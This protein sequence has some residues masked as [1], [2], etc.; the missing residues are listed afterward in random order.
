MHKSSSGLDLPMKILDMFGSGLPVIAL[1]YPV[2]DELVQHDV[3]GLKFI[4]RRELHE[5]LIFAVK[6]AEVYKVLK[7]GA[8]SESENR[9]EQSWEKALQELKIVR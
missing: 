4:D 3:N 7:D 2:L 6:D 5:A 1:N 9:W 8:L